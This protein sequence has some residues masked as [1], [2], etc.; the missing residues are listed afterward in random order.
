MKVHDTYTMPIENHNPMELSATLA[1][2]PGPDHLTLYDATQG[3]FVVQQRAAEIFGIPRD[4]VRVFTRFVGG[5]FGCKGSPWSHVLLAAM[6]AKVTG[7]PVKL[8]L[9][10]Q[11][12]FQMVGYRPQLVQHVSLG[13]KKDGAL[14]AMRH[15]V[16]SQTSRFDEFMEPAAYATRML[17]ACPN[18][19][20]RTAW[21]VSTCRR[22]RSCA[23][24]ASR[25]VRSRWSR[26]WTS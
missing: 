6:G 23:P 25:A 17:Y 8:M 18:V 24:R 5:A 26:R 15:E 10:R 12:M 4:N 21:C 13:A 1:V 20:R 11:Q 2:W 3:V 16:L 14:V 19:R 7:R 9:T 22:R